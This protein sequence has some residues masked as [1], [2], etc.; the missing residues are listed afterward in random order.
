MRQVNRLS[1]SF[2]FS[3]VQTIPE[4]WR[5]RHRRLEVWN[6]VLSKSGRFTWQG[7]LFISRLLLDHL[8]DTLLSSSLLILFYDFLLKFPSLFFLIIPS[9]F[10][11]LIEVEVSRLKTFV[12]DHVLLNNLIRPHS[13]LAN[14]S[15]VSWKILPRTFLD[16]IIVKPWTHL[17]HVAWVWSVEFISGVHW[18][19]PLI[20]QVVIQVDFLAMGSLLKIGVHLSSV[21]ENYR[22]HMKRILDPILH[23]CLVLTFE[24]LGIPL[25]IWLE[26]PRVR[27]IVLISSL[28]VLFWRMN[29]CGP[30]LQKAYSGVLFVKV[31]L[32]LYETSLP[33]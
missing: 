21:L 19:L 4:L 23:V 7:S 14:I 6:V 30:S 15:P 1:K 20:V 18:G 26:K 12:F 10:L 25:G 16:L 5:N 24:P 13:L 29:V 31:F 28:K 33:F 11:L 27:V 8:I 2:P 32:V 9:L 17:R 22:L 3:W